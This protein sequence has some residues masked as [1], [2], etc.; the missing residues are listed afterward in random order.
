MEL[1]IPQIKKHHRNDIKPSVNPPCVN[2]YRDTPFG[3]LTLEECEDLFR[4]RIEALSII[5]KSDISEN[6]IPV[7]ASS[8]RDVKSYVYKTNC[9]VTNDAQHRRLDNFSHMLTRLY[10]VYQPMLWDWFKKNEKKLFYYRMKDHASSLSSPQLAAILKDF[11]FDAEMVVGIEL[12]KLI[13]EQVVGW[14]KKGSDIQDIFKVK[15]MDAL[16]FISKRSV[17]LKDGYAFLGRH[18]I[19]NVVCDAFERY[20][21]RELQYARQHVNVDLHQTQHLLDS[22][23]V[24]FLDFKERM[25]EEKKL[26]QQKKEGESHNPYRINVSEIPMLMKEHYP[27]CM[28]Y[29]QEV[30]TQDHHLKHQARLYYGAFLKAGGVDVES[31]TE[32]FR[33]EFTKK[34]PREKFDR[35][36]KYNIRH[37]Y[38]M[39]GHKKAL[40]CFSCDKIVNDNPPGPTEKHGCP[41]RHFDDNNLKSMITKHGLKEVDIE[42]IFIQRNDKEYKLACSHY[43]K[44]IKGKFP[45]EPIKTPIHYYYESMRHANRPHTPEGDLEAS[46]QNM[47]IDDQKEESIRETKLI[48]SQASDENWDD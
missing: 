19:I 7:I 38:G 47:M 36:Y 4:Q 20:L 40:S 32:L 21:D 48:Q 42:S 11:D 30:L 33:Q 9:I 14:N 44:S 37:L 22:L 17:S 15:F 39:E 46:D 26:Q 6:Q 28:R 8:L 45:S 29:I 34:I 16:R 27:P 43:F 5:E 1:D 25:D 35:D 12:N 24:V 10:C 18:E 41:F 31:A 13:A 3:Q 2:L 23:S